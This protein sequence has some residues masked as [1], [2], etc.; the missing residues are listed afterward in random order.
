MKIKQAFIKFHLWRIRNI[1]NK[2][3]L[4]ILSIVIGFAGGLVAAIIKNSVHFI[5]TLLTGG[6]SLEYGN[7]LYF[8]Y[9]AIGIT[10]SVLFMRYVLRKWVGHGIPGVLYA[11]SRKSGKME[12]HNIYSSIVTS[13]FTVGFG[14]SVGLEGPTVA[15]GAGIGSNIA[16]WLRLNYKD[17]ILI[18]GA[19]STAAMSAIFKAPITGIVYVLEIIML[20]LNLTSLMA[21]LLAST[22][23]VLTS[24]AFLGK[25]VIYPVNLHFELDYSLLPYFVLLAI[26]T[27]LMSLYYYNTYVAIY[28]FFGKLKT[29]YY[30]LPVGT[31]ILGGLILLFPS[32]YGEGYESINSALN[33]DYIHLFEKTFFFGYHTD[34]TALI[35]ILLLVILVKVVAMTITF[36]SGGVGGVFA[37]T[38]FIGSH[39]GLG[40]ALFSNH[41]FGTHFDPVVF[42]LLGMTGMISGVLHGPLTGIFLIAEITSSYDMFVPLMIVSSTS[43]FIVRVFHKYSIYT[44]QLAKRGELITHDKDKSALQ[45]LEIENLLETNFRT[46]KK[47]YS[48]RQLIKEIEQSSRNLF[49][50]LDD[51]GNLEGLVL[52]DDVRKIMF[53]PEYYDKVYVK[54][55]MYKLKE[56][57]IVDIDKDNMEEV[58]NKFNTTGHYNLP[59]VKN[60]KYLGFLSRANV[61]TSYRKL[62]NLFSGE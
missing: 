32:L 36:A 24:Y 21:L 6:F 17:T 54:D 20:D 53:K 33:G 2:N 25:D 51:N 27:G 56:Q 22:S 15:T 8:I 1:S 49:P 14:G 52:L 19:A 50:V 42:A 13:A 30:R 23:A 28:N 26:V 7:Y 39:L 3:F 61:F 59:V 38:L 57:E 31:I 5:R 60:G 47:D 34:F 4:F 18:V 46:V 35:I 58:V 11:I 37:P 41:F 43:F 45:M 9:P 48:L 10:L 16:Q 12:P 29:W 62:I 40:F 55:V 44:Y